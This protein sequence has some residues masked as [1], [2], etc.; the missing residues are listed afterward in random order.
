MT[1]GTPPTSTDLEVRGREIEDRI[2]RLGQSPILEQLSISKGPNAHQSPNEAPFK[3]NVKIR[4][5]LIVGVFILGGP[6]IALLTKPSDELPGNKLS[7]PMSTI[8]ASGKS[9]NLPSVINDDRASINESSDVQFDACQKDAFHECYELERYRS[10]TSRPANA[11]AS[12][13]C[14]LEAK[15]NCAGDGAQKRRDARTIVD[16]AKCA[17]EAMING[18]LNGY[19]FDHCMN[20]R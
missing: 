5:A 12:E 15:A 14:A 19:F 3:L 11:T 4:I 18:R 1:L 20:R 8:E 9:A 6:I 17:Q 10:D 16:E 13:W 7:V 2:R